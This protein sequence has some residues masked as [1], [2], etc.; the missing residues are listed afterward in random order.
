MYLI[1]II[2]SEKNSSQRVVYFMFPFLGAFSK[3]QNYG[4]GNLINGGQGLWL[5]R[6]CHCEGIVQ[7]ISWDNRTILCSNCCVDA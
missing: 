4:D 3:S 7:E 2:V 5:G 1:D 6:W